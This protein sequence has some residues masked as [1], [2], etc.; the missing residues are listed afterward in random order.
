M[1]QQG[2]PCKKA[3]ECSSGGNL[4]K[5]PLEVAKILRILLCER[6]FFDP[7]EIPIL[8][9]H[10][11]N[12]FITFFNSDKSVDCQISPVIFFWLNTL[13]GT[14]KAPAWYQDRIFNPSRYD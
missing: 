9:L 13:K 6:V 1:P 5:I 3:G 11:T 2:I 4:K 10:I 12:T 14:A 7:L 8:N